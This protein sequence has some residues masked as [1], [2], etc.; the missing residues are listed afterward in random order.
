MVARLSCPRYL[1]RVF[2]APPPLLCLDDGEEFF[3]GLL[4]HL[5]GILLLLWPGPCPV[6]LPHQPLPMFVLQDLLPPRLPLKH[7][8]EM[9]G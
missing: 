7:L 4:E 9:R 8:G 1:F 2:L 5:L 3:S 6:L